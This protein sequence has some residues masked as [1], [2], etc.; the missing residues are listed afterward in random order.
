MTVRAGAKL[1]VWQACSC[2]C[3]A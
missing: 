3:R 1:S 2:D